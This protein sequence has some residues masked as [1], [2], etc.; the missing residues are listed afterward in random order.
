MSYTKV[1]PSCPVLRLTNTVNSQTFRVEHSDIDIFL[2]KILNPPAYESYVIASVKRHEMGVFR[3]AYSCSEPAASEQRVTAQTGEEVSSRG[4]SGRFRRANS[5]GLP[6]RQVGMLTTVKFYNCSP[7]A[8]R[9]KLPGPYNFQCRTR[10]DL[11]R[12]FNGLCRHQNLA[13]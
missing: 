8:D 1:I 11:F 2:L 13:H 5:R 6:D 4:P 10:A 3:V 9:H 12:H 7:A